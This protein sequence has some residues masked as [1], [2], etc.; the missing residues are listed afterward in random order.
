MREKQQER[1]R[2]RKAEIERKGMINHTERERQRERE[3][4]R[5]IE[6]KLGFFLPKFVTSWGGKKMKNEKMKKN[7]KNEKNEKNK[8][9][10]EEFHI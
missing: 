9:K 3:T 2:F 8:K 7:E 1:E 10:G 4:E 6:R 5:A